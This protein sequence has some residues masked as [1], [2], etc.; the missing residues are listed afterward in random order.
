MAFRF[1]FVEPGDEVRSRFFLY[2]FDEFFVENKEMKNGTGVTWSSTCIT[3]Y[4]QI[5][6]KMVFKASVRIWETQEVENEDLT[7]GF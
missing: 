5:V 3:A 6:T 1:L 2:N 7:G 4:F